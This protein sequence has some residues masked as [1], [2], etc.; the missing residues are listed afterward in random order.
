MA[1]DLYLTRIEARNLRTTIDLA[2]STVLQHFN[3]SLIN[4]RETYRVYFLHQ[5]AY[6]LSVNARC[7]VLASIK[8]L[9]KE[10]G[11]R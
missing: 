8:V 10:P 6:D 11:T 4:W 3:T 9:S 7:A 2:G 1:R 5:R